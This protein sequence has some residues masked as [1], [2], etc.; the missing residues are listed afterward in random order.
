M[1]RIKNLIFFKTFF[2]ISFVKS[3][4]LY[5]QKIQNFLMISAKLSF[6][7]SFAY[8]FFKTFR[9]KRNYV[10]FRWDSGL[11]IETPAL[12]S[13]VSYQCLFTMEGIGMFRFLVCFILVHQ[14][15]EG[16][17]PKQDPSYFDCPTIKV[18]CRGD[19]ATNNLNHRYSNLIMGTKVSSWKRCGETLLIIKHGQ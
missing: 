5:L 9:T 13:Q 18:S 17:C 16:G 3:S 7:W 2:N 15:L 6:I 1:I 11:P 12:L 10:G 19:P 14:S 8:W 4:D